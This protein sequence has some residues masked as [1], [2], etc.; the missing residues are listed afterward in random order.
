[1]FLD[2]QGTL[3]GKGLGDDIRDFTFYPFVIP[4]IKLLNEAGLLTILITNQTR[5]ARGFFT[6]EYFLERMEILK[7][8]LEEGG[9]RLDAVYCCPHVD[10]DNCL[11]KKPK[12]GMVLTAQ[13][14]FDLDLSTC[15]VIGDRGDWD[16]G[17]AN[18][19]GCKGILVRTGLGEGSIGEFRY[20]WESINPDYV[21]EDVLDAVK[22]I[23]N[24][25]VRVTKGS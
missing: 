6:Y 1:M 21:A 7:K 16:M 14:D 25:R 11:C 12:P 17:L 5:I 15:Y 3:G 18:T 8:E 4:A 10:E 9:A 24:D 2:F 20:T 13:K 23:L 22:W 19:V